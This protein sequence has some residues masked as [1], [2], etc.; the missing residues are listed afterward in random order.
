MGTSPE[1]STITT[2][3]NLT[4]SR[5][6]AS[7]ALGA[8]RGAGHLVHRD[9]GHIIAG[10]VAPDWMS[11]RG[12]EGEKATTA[13]GR[14]SPSTSQ[15]PRATPRIHSRTRLTV[16]ESLPCAIVVDPSP[17][18]VVGVVFLMGTA[19]EVRHASRRDQKDSS[20]AACSLPVMHPVDT[21]RSIEI[22]E[23]AP[24]HGRHTAPPLG[25]ARCGGSDP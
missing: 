2:S 1:R 12:W 13:R 7:A 8:S 23:F 9:A 25:D 4:S 5:T 16:P 11:Y 22:A 24:R 6:P 17:P 15:P 19:V 21:H 10:V 18:L 3:S 20:P 14:R